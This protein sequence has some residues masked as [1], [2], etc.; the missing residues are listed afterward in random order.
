MNTL[1]MISRNLV[2]F[3]LYLSSSFLFSCQSSDCREGPDVSGVEVNNDFIRWD[4]ALFEAQSK[5]DIENLLQQYPDFSQK[6]LHRDQYPHDSAL[7][8]ALYRL[9]QNPSIDSLYQQVQQT[10]G[11]AAHLQAEFAD[12]FRHIK[13]YYP[14]FTPPPVFITFSGLGTVGDDVL[15]SDSLMVVSLEFFIGKK[16]RYRPQAYDYQLQRYQPEFVVP[17][18]MLLYSNRFNKTDPEDQTLLAE[19]VYYGK[20]YYF[21]QQIMPCVPDSTI[22][23]YLPQAIEVVANNP[24][25]IWR[26]FVEKELLYETSHIIKQRYLGER[27]STVEINAQIPGQV[28][29]WLGWQIVQKYATTTN[30]TL[31]EVMGTV[32]AQRLFTQAKYRP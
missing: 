19:M 9:V 31:P 14:D 29:R 18:C 32:D 5:Q 22:I 4:E 10:F 17:S 8:N 12:A 7:V 23:G 26:H 27:P 13:Y 20:S 3:L 15:V 6:Y 2:T 28:G 24:S 25:L 30:A 11:N 16:A 21:V 1:L